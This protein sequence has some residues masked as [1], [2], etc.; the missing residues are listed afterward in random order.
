M[1]VKDIAQEFITSYFNVRGDFFD[2]AWDFV[3]A[4]FDKISSLASSSEGIKSIGGPLAF[5]GHEEQG[6]VKAILIFADGFRELPLKSDL[7]DF[8]DSVR[9][10]C[11]KYHAEVRL[12]EEILKKVSSLENRI[13]KFMKPELPIR[14]VVSGKEEK[15]EYV[16]FLSHSS[17][18]GA[19]RDEKTEKAIQKDYLNK[20]EGY[21]IFIYG[22]TVY[23]KIKIKSGDRTEQNIV[24]VDLDENVFNL[25]LIFLI[26]KDKPIFA[27]PLYHKACEGS[28]EHKSE[29]ISA[30]QIMDDLKQAVSQLRLSFEDVEGFDIPRARGK[31]DRR[32]GTYFLRG[33]FKF[34]AIVEKTLLN[35]YILP[36]GQQQVSHS[37]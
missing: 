27:L 11:G 2:T 22:R 17:G 13:A 30:V 32:G 25:L 10:A 36:E 6:A 7:S 37:Q 20:K 33:K 35:N 29:A 15:A 16:I 5:G 12:T 23:K 21:D 14:A 4:N 18:V 9:T 8:V 31:R 19:V 26:Y 3:S 1:E 28:R 24:S 34:C